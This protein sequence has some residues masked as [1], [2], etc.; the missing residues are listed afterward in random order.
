MFAQ[1]NHMAMISNQYSILEKY[2]QVLFGFR[3]SD[4]KEPP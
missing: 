4:R 2:Y 3:L 1:I